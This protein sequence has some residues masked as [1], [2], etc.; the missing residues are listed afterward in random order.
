LV[1]KTFKDIK[2]QK[3]SVPGLQ[4]IS[5]QEAMK[6]DYKD[7]KVGCEMSPT[8]ATFWFRLEITIPQDFKNEKV[9][10]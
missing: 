1:A 10:I 8:W 3:Y 5:F 9:K 4:R 6:G 2:L 7:A